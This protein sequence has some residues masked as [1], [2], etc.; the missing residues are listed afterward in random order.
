MHFNYL[1]TKIKIYSYYSHTLTLSEGM[2]D[3]A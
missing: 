1:R 2:T 3:E